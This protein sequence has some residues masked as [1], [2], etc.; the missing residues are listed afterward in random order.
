VSKLKIL[1][2]AVDIG[3]RI[4]SY[5]NFLRN[6]NPNLEITSFVKYKVSNKQYKTTYDYEE[7]YP[8]YSKVRQWF[9]SFRFFLKSLF[10]FNTYYF[11]SGETILTRKLRHLEFKVY[12]ALNK[13]LIMH[14]V[15]SDIRDP[16]YLYW[17]S[18]NII[19]FLNDKI[20]T[21]QTA[22][23][24][25]NL[26]KDSDNYASSVLVSTPDLLKIIPLATYYPVV[27]DVNS[28]INEIGT[29]SSKGTYFK[30]NKI[31]ILHAPSNTRLKGSEIINKV[32]KEIEAETGLIEF[33][34][35]KDLNQE[36]ATVYTVSR[37]EL[38]KLYNETDVVIDQLI[39]GW[40]GLQAIEALLA[41]CHVFCYI[42]DDLEEY[43]FPDCPIKNINA[44]NIKEK[45]LHFLEN[46]SAPDSH[47]QISWV[48][49]HHSIE[50]NNTVLTNAIFS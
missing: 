16:N 17:K 7:N 5:S 3:W 33:I 19:A 21:S 31:K 29:F 42:A 43:L 45:L 4:K 49:Q 50:Q 39:I 28:F 30:T 9:V 46:Y 32:L 36:T 2:G 44:I 12:K 35:T 37:Y 24:Q 8:T 25:Q 6:E 23:W 20:E 26:I 27:L 40:Y 15:G 41:E 1:F 18:D 11:F 14:F 22:D 48:K 47:E 34:Y 13:K 10:L 38:F